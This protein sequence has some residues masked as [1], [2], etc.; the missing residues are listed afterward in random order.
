MDKSLQVTSLAPVITYF[1][2]NLR[3]D[4]EEE[5]A[6]SVAGPSAAQQAQRSS[7]VTLPL[8]HRALLQS[9]ASAFEFSTSK[10]FSADSLLL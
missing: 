7:P 6:S 9:A 4:Q 1:I 5:Q 10:I 3:L 8:T 2:M